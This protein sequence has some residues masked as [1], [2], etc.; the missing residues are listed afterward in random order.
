MKCLGVSGFTRSALP[1]ARSLCAPVVRSMSEDEEQESGCN[2]VGGSPAS[3]ASTSLRGNN[4]YHFL[5]NNNHNNLPSL[6]AMVAPP[7]SPAAQSQ[8][9]RSVRTM[10]VPPM[11]LQNSNSQGTEESAQRAGQWSLSILE[12]FTFSQS[13]GQE[14]TQS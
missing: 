4:T 5:D 12:S 3:D 10:V 7:P 8:S 14:N 1:T 9:T 6:P 11:T 13:S 2:T